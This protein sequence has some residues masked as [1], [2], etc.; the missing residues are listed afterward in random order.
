MLPILN[1]TIFPRRSIEHSMMLAELQEFSID[2]LIEQAVACV[3]PNLFDPYDAVFERWDAAIL[4]SGC[5]CFVLSIRAKNLFGSRI[6]LLRVAKATLD[7]MNDLEWTVYE[8]DK[9]VLPSGFISGQVPSHLSVPLTQSSVARTTIAR[10][11]VP[12]TNEG[13]RGLGQ[14]VSSWLSENDF[15]Q[16]AAAF[17]EN[18]IDEAILLDGLSDADLKELGVSKLG[19]R[20]RLIKLIAE[21]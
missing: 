3:K 19:H 10:P 11:S 12:Q 6:P 9:G 18:E 7:E 15:G 8:Y 20:K 2:T 16:Y 13:T 21:L 14:D 17:E 5:I 4:R 1:D